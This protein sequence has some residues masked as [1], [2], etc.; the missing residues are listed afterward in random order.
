MPTGKPSSDGKAVP[1]A[2]SIITHRWVEEAVSEKDERNARAERLLLTEQEIIRA[3]GSDAYVRADAEA[4][5]SA[6]GEV[7]RAAAVESAY[8]RFRGRI[9][10]EDV[11]RAITISCLALV[12]DSEAVTDRTFRQVAEAA[13]LRTRLN[14]VDVA[15]ETVTAPSGL[16]SYWGYAEAGSVIVVVTLDTVDPREVS[17]AELR[18]I[19]S[20]LVTRLGTL[21][22]GS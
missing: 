22:S 3:L 12:F 15:V 11:E 7:L 4:G 19:L 10:V 17:I 5:P 13:H 9:V 6:V 8:R 20:V 14:D 18:S 1:G 16:V 2:W 21:D